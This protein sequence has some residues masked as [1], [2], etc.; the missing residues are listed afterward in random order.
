[1]AK[2]DDKKQH[3]LL[4]NFKNKKTLAAKNK[5]QSIKTPDVVIEPS[6]AGRKS[7]R[8]IDPRDL[9]KPPLGKVNL[10][11][12]K[13]TLKLK[14]TA[15]LPSLPS[16]PDSLKEDPFKLKKK[17]ENN[18]LI[19]LRLKLIEEYVWFCVQATLVWFFVLSY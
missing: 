19:G 6:T 18:D 5:A 14:M 2:P 15:K 4:E 3:S 13:Q 11:T 7:D 12:D 16:K 10:P 9:L 1:M 8:T 17:E